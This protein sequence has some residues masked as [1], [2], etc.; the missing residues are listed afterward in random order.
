MTPEARS[1]ILSE[2]LLKVVNLSPLKQ[3]SKATLSQ[4]QGRAA[5]RGPFPTK[6]SLTGTAQVSK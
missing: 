6:V 3:S 4:C 5:V 1:D 2:R